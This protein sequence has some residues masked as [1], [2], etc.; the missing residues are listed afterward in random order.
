MT[1]SKKINHGG[2]PT[3]Y[4]ID[5]VRAVFAKSI[6]GGESVEKIEAKNVKAMLVSSFGVSNGI[7]VRS[8]ETMVDHVR[9]EIIDLERK[10]LIKSLPKSVTHIVQS[11]TED[12][13]QELLLLFAKTRNNFQA[14]ANQ[15]CEE[16]RRD[17]A[18]ANWR[19]AELEGHLERKSNEVEVIG[20]KLEVA[21]AEIIVVQQERDAALSALDD[22]QK[23]AGPV[24]QLIAHL[25]DPSVRS[26]IRGVLAEIAR[27]NPA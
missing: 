26:D 1:Q 12:L 2:R 3:A 22:H 15:E 27:E 18:N 23:A 4:S 11:M 25:Q 20:N 7:D 8:L 24:E 21:L 5:Q 17:K 14:E 9:T 16:L 6:D 10:A 19:I 13:G